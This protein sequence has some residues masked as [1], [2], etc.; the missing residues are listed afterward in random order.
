MKMKEIR[1][2]Q[3]TKLAP[4]IPLLRTSC[5]PKGEKSELM[6][7]SKIHFDLTSDFGTKTHNKIS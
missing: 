5:G 6:A 7:V 2:Q 4:L 3:T 1:F